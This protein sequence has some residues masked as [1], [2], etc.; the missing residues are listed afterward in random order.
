MLMTQFFF[1]MHRINRI[2]GFLSHHHTLNIQNPTKYNVT[3]FKPARI[4][5]TI[6]K[7]YDS[8]KPLL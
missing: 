8:I 5:V 7:K 4:K 6:E 3:L 1:R 2:I